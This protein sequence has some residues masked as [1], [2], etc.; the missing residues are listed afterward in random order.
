MQTTSKSGEEDVV[1]L[2]EMTANWADVEW[3]CKR[4]IAKI[5]TLTWP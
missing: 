4:A 1:R 3:M 2:K 5:E